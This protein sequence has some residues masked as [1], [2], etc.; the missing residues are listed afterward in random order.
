MATKKLI[1][2]R[3]KRLLEAKR[4]QKFIENWQRKNKFDSKKLVEYNS[5]FKKDLNSYLNKGNFSSETKKLYK[6]F[7]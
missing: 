6:I 2:E 7:N 3:K 1:D 4:I 5:K